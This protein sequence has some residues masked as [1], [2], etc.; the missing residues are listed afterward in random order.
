MTQGSGYTNGNQLCHQRSFAIAQPLGLERYKELILTQLTL[1]PPSAP[2]TLALQRGD[3]D[4]IKYEG[5][6]KTNGSTCLYNFLQPPEDRPP[7]KF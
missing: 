3:L 1:P 6:H 4:G 5:S 7:P 2:S